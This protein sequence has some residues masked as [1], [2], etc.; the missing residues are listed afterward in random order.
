[1]SSSDSKKKHEFLSVS[2][3]LKLLLLLRHLPNLAKLNTRFENVG[4][5]KRERSKT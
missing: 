3:A 5:Q 1:M 4:E 2:G